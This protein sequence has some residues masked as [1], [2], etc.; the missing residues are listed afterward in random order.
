MHHMKAPPIERLIEVVG[1][2]ERAS[3]TCALGASG[4][5]ISLGIWSEAHDWDLTTD[6][7][8]ERVRAALASFESTWHG[9]SGIHADQK[10]VVGAGEVECIVGFAIRSEAGVAR[11]PTVVTARW[12]GVPVGSPEAWAVAYTL[13]GRDEKAALLFDW[14]TV[15][16]ADEDIRRRLLEQPL[17]GNV[18]AR[19]SALPPRDTSSST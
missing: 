14:L 7:P 6:A 1:A 10:L 19:L 4:L 12:R 8:I 15:H 18:A 9:S 3:V 13:L 17:P 11:I 16:G 2:L 5:L